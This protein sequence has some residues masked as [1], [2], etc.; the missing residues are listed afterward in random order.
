MLSPDIVDRIQREEERRRRE[1]DRVPL[2]QPLDRVPEE[3]SPPAE[4]QAA[5]GSH[6][7]VINVSQNDVDEFT[8]L[9]W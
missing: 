2:E 1:S 3:A 8:V 7:V 5:P 9:S 4:E 6:V